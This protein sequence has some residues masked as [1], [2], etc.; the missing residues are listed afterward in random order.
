MRHSILSLSTA[1]T[2]LLALFTWFA[3]TACGGDGGAK[4]CCE[5]NA[6]VCV[7]GALQVCNA[8]G[9]DLV[10][11]PC[12]SGACSGNDCLTP[13]QCQGVVGF[14]R[15]DET[16]PNDRTLITCS[17]SGTEMTTL[18]EEGSV[19]VAGAC[20]P[21]PCEVGEKMCGF[22]NAAI[23]DNPSGYMELACGAGEV[24]DETTFECVAMNCEPGA[25]TCNGNDVV[26][27]D[28]NGGG[29][30]TSPCGSN[31][32][33]KDGHCVPQV[34]GAPTNPGDAGSSDASGSDLALLDIPS[35]PDTIQIQ[36]IAT[37]PPDLKPLSKASVNI[38]GE[39]LTFTSGKDAGW[40]A[41]GG[42]GSTETGNALQISM[43]KG[44]KKLE[45]IIRGI[46]EFQVGQWASDDTAEVQIELRWS[47]G[48]IQVGQGEMGCSTQGW[49]AC[50][51]SYFVEISAFEQ[52]GGRVKA[53]FEA[54]LFDGTELTEGTL[55]VER[56]Q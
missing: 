41:L 24:C 4:T 26:V 49:T 1:R 53:S 36:D 50:S 16:D 48:I 3:V 30:T 19:C 39:P 22:V 31:E 32:S 44:G 46:Q 2:A 45:I 14:A 40:V 5:A 7:D 37:N 55:D 43:A 27:C 25:R 52:I 54:T 11:T 35:I 10:I 33:C 47:D 42:E 12:S 23:C 56:V 18:C 13:K 6:Q 34:C 8:A 38:N 51:Q 20:L 21:L 29:Q 15:C 9:D 28:P 17:P